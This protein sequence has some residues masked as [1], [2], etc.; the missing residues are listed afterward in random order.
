M[1]VVQI[2]RTCCSNLKKMKHKI[3]GDSHVV[4][5]F[6]ATDMLHAFHRP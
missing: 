2:I 6:Q 5:G 4:P 1:Q 3:K